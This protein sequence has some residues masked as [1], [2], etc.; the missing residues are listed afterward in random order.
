[1]SQPTLRG[2]KCH[3]GMTKVSY[4]GHVF[5]ANGM[6]PDDQKVQAVK[7]WPT[8]SDV[9]ALRQFLGLASFY[10]RYISGFANIASPLHDLTKKGA[11]FAWTPACSAAFDSLKNELIRAPILTYTRFDHEAGPFTVYTDASGTGLGTVLEQD[12]K[13]IAFASRVLT[14]PE[15]QYSVIQRECLAVVYAL[16]QF[17]HYLLGRPFKLV[18]DHAPLL[19]L[20]AQKMEGLLCRWALALQE[21]NFSIV[22]KMPMQMPSPDVTTLWFESLVP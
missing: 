5:S 20:S 16:K 11:T 9:A 6:T 8:P 1:M 18:T 12:D 10:R 15:C 3:L 17:R 4:L 22:Y 13:V 7:D 2:Q 21:Y 14:K 19:W